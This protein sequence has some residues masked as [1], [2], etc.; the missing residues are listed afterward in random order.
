MT[1]VGEQNS[2]RLNLGLQLAG[3]AVKYRVFISEAGTTTSKVFFDVDPAYP[4]QHTFF[5]HGIHYVKVGKHYHSSAH[6]NIIQNGA[7]KR[8]NKRLLVTATI[9]S[10]LMHGTD[11]SQIF[12][13]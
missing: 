2:L 5:L 12:E 4:G 6:L 9:I 13:E 11:A 1:G 10:L 3:Q 8:S 7:Q